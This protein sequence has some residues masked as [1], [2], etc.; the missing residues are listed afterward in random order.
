MRAAMCTAFGP[1]EGVRIEEVEPPA[2]QPGCVRVRV[3]FASANPPDVLMPSRAQR[4]DDLV[5]FLFRHD[6]HGDDLLKLDQ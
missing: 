4:V 6:E 1:L 3:A 5:V 2:L